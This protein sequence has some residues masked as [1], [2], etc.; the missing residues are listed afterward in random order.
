VVAEGLERR[1]D[2]AALCDLGVDAAQGFLLGRPSTSHRQLRKWLRSSS[3][4]TSEEH[5]AGPVVASRSVH[6]A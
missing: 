5:S 2:L 1:A 4:T 6:D 3:F